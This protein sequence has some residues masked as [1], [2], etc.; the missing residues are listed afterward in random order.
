MRININITPQVGKLGTEPLI[1]IGVNEDTDKLYQNIIYLGHPRFNMDPSLYIRENSK[2]LLEKYTQLYMDLMRQIYGKKQDENE[3]ASVIRFEVQ[4]ANVTLMSVGRQY[5]RTTIKDLNKLHPDLN[6]LEYIQTVLQN[7]RVEI[8]ILE[9]EAVTLGNDSYF[10][11]LFQLLKTTPAYVIIKYCIW[12]YVYN[13][14]EKTTTAFSTP[15]AIFKSTWAGKTELLANRALRC[16][17]ETLRYFP[18]PVGRAYTE[19]HFPFESKAAVSEMIKNILQVFLDKVQ[20]A[21]WITEEAKTGVVRKVDSLNIRVGF[22]EKY[23]NTSVLD[24]LYVKTQMTQNYFGNVVAVEKQVAFRT[25][26]RLTRP[27]DRDEWMSFSMNAHSYYSESV[28]QMSFPAVTLKSPLFEH[29]FSSPLNYGGIGVIIGHEI[30]NAFDDRGY[31]I[32]RSGHIRQWLM[33]SDVLNF[34]SNSRCMMNQ[35]WNFQVCSVIFFLS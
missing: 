4:L 23:K 21:S 3:A 12:Q 2:N 7:A 16:L 26:N 15:I 27:V 17:S 19:R 32:D 8:K 13:Y 30:M 31:I 11:R 14:A 33:K 28:D 25:F 35:Y 1:V 18:L 24:N 5:E 10:V 6:W 22:P 29:W 9:T 34:T 20:K